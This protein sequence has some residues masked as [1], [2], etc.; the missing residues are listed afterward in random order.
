MKFKLE[1]LSNLHNEGRW[2]IDYHLPAEGI[3]KFG[4][5]IL[6]PVSE[7]ATIVKEKRDPTR[8]PDKEFNYLDISSVDVKTGAVSTP[9]LL[10]G[11]EAPSRARKVIHAYD[12]IISTCRPTRGAIAV[13]PEEYHN[14]ICST[15]F[16]V[17]RP[18]K[19]IN[20]YYLHFALRLSSTLE[21][22]RKFSTGS[23]YPAILDS[24]V[25]KTLIPLPDKET[26]DLLAGHILNGLRAREAAIQA[27][28][29]TF[30]TKLDTAVGSLKDEK[31]KELDSEIADLSYKT[32]EI[33]KRLHGL[34]NEGEKFKLKG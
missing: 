16:S 33:A 6:H 11:S 27:A 21:Q 26:Q 28:N 19:G 34:L 15:G 12:L 20:P 7:A 5:D 24:D 23:S 25:K 31:F 29:S 22:F 8:K 9:Q 17:I 10:T 1:S 4:N 32:D 3:T 18:K 13:I 30:Q 2:D 14:Q